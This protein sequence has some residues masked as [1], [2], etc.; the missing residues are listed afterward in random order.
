M[1]FV[2]CKMQRCQQEPAIQKHTMGPTDRTH[3]MASLD[4]THGPTNMVCICQVILELLFFVSN[5]SYLKDHIFKEEHQRDLTTHKIYQWVSLRVFLAE[6]L[7][8]DDKPTFS[9]A[10]SSKH[11]IFMLN[12]IYHYESVHWEGKRTHF[13]Q[14]NNLIHSAI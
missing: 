8:P 1:L 14:V 13:K 2:S 10:N 3:H 5:V 4:R 6:D 9:K 12:K 11:Y 7:G